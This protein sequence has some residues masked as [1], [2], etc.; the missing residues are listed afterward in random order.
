MNA[1]KKLMK[2]IGR[3]RM[4]G[5]APLVMAYLVGNGPEV[6]HEDVI[7]ESEEAAANALLQED[8]QLLVVRFVSPEDARP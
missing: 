3:F 6:E 4:S 7:F 5:I 8:Q 1:A 2:R